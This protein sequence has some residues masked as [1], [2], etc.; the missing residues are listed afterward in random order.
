MIR[1]AEERDFDSLI[2]IAIASELFEPEETDLISQM[3]RGQTETDIWLTAEGEE[4][5]VGVAYLAPEKMTSGTWNLLMIAVHPD[6]QRFGVGKAILD[7]V[8]SWLAENNGRMLIIETAGVPEFDYVRAFY[9][10]EGF[11]QEA[12][13]RDFYEASV[14]KVVFRKVL[15]SVN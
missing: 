14:D 8:E 11:Q 9:A 12:T 1:R 4:N 13:I 7:Y 5:P 10:R 15:K 2:E 6:H 3:L